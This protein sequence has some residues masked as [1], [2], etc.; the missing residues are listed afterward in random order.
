MYTCMYHPSLRFFYCGPKS[1]DFWPTSK[2]FLS[3]KGCN[4]SKDTIL[5]ENENLITDQKQVCEIFGEGP[6]V[7]RLI[8]P[9]TPTRAYDFSISQLTDI[10]KTSI[11]T[12]TTITRKETKPE[13]E[14]N[15][16]NGNAM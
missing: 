16:K 13:K 10:P 2:P 6:I 11:K 4:T 7:R 12:G 5:T 15:S 14:T 8:C 3:S 1:K 9:T